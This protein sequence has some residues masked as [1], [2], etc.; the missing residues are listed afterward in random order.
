MAV[1]FCSTLAEATPAAEVEIVG[2]AALL[3]EERVADQLGLTDAQRDAIATVIDDRELAGVDV[4]LSIQSLPRDQR[5]AR[6][7][8]FR[9]ESLRQAQALLTDKQREAFEAIAAAQADP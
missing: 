9:S 6:L 4:A 2:A 8:P 1:L 5:L 7:A 3:L